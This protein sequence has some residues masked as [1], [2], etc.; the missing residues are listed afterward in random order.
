MQEECNKA[1]W[2]RMLKAFSE[3]AENYKPENGDYK[4]NDGLIYC[5]K[6]HTPKQARVSL[7]GTETIMW[8]DCAC[9][10]AEYQAQKEAVRSASRRSAI[11]DNR[12]SAFMEEKP[13]NWRFENDNGEHKKIMDIAH[14]YADNFS[15][16]VTGL[17]FYGE[18]GTGKSFAS[19][20]I[21][22][23]LLEK[24]YRC[25]MTSF[26]I[27]INKLNGM[28]EGKQE[29]I[30]RLAGYDLLVIDDLGAER[31]TEY[32]K[33]IVYNIIN[34]RANSGKPTII[35][36]NYSA[37]RFNAP[38]T[39]Q[40]KRIFSRICEMCVFIK[41]EGEDARKAKMKENTMRMRELLSS[42]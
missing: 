13:K 31:N 9:K 20:C 19:G 27:E 2:V 16:S 12:S 24:G 5:G 18:T 8:G 38:E 40:E 6:C 39:E 22:N 37:A 1:A 14:R 21:L 30:D 34:A 33:E 10:T 11:S 32:A 29:H 23:A 3:R 42:V 35:T 28:F 36:T 41:V 26:L 17:L 7:F 4:G 25:C 15:T